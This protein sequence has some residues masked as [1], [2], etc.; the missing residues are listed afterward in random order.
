MTELIQRGIG[1]HAEA[2]ERHEYSAVELLRAYLTQIEKREPE[3]GAY[4][5][6][7][8]ENALRNAEASDARRAKGETLGIFDGI[9]YALKDNFCTDGLRTTCA[10]RMLE[11]FGPPYDAAVVSKLKAAGA[12]L[13]GK[14]NMDEFAM[15]S[16]TETSALGVTRNPI[17]PDYV[18]GEATESEFDALPSAD[19]NE[20]KDKHDNE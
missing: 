16:A 10:S 18:P 2:L 8:A 4:L 13:L 19:N 11:H 20:E 3:V 6:L 7:D 1:A 5:T 9:P 17:H 15:G 14:A 12:I